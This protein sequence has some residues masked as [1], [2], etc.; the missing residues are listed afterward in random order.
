MDGY[1]RVQCA[2]VEQAIYDYKKALKKRNGGK[3]T[4][5][6]RWFLS[7]WGEMLSGGNGKYIIE[8]CRNCVGMK[9]KPRNFKKG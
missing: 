5:F 4:Y 9:R 2:I 6:E 7:E 3:I 1:K 8:Q